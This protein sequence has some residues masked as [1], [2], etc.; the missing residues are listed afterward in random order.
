M[1]PLLSPDVGTDSVLNVPDRVAD[2][3]PSHEVGDPLPH[4]RSSGA[5]LYIG[6]CPL[7]G[8]SATSTPPRPVRHTALLSSEPPDGT[9][10]HRLPV[11]VMAGHRTM[12]SGQTVG[13]RAANIR[14]YVALRRP[15]REKLE[16]R[17]AA[18]DGATGFG[19]GPP[20]IEGMPLIRASVMT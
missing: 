12:N 13:I 16:V 6:Q 7:C 14:P 20:A 4:L 10:V 19:G 5:W 15:H 17:R 3:G 18:A 9:N 11:R 8:I 1:L 2:A